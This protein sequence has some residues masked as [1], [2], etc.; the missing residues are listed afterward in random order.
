[1]K[2]D[3]RREGGRIEMEVVREESVQDGSA[4]KE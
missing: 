2:D 1:M 4:G 3:R